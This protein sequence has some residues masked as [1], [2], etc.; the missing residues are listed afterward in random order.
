MSCDVNSRI[1]SIPSGE[2]KVNVTGQEEAVQVTA[3]AAGDNRVEG[4]NWPDRFYQE[5]LPDMD[6]LIVE[7]EL[8]VQTSG[9]WYLERQ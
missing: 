8:E 4:A 6:R 3:A 1:A 5:Q 2:N 9:A 7:Y